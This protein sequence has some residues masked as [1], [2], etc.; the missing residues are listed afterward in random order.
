LFKKEDNGFKRRFNGIIS[1]REGCGDMR[2]IKG[3]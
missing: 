2:K 1:K 3:R